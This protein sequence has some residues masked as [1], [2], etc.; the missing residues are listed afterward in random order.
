MHHFVKS[1]NAPMAARSL[2]GEVKHCVPQVPTGVETSF[3][4]VCFTLGVASAPRCKSQLRRHLYDGFRL[5]VQV[6]CAAVALR[7]AK[8]LRCHPEDT[9]LAVAD[10]NRRFAWAQQHKAAFAEVSEDLCCRGACIDLTIL[11]AIQAELLRLER[12]T[13]SA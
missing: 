10:K 2:P 4:K 8:L 11:K 12:L 3:G 5:R 7:R 13:S 6:E 1:Q 9:I